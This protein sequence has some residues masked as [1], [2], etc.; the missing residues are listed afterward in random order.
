MDEYPDSALLLLQDIA[1]PQILRGKER[2]DYALLY[3]QACDKNYISKS[4][5]SSNHTKTLGSTGESWCIEKY[6]CFFEL[7]LFRMCELEQRK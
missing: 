2:A 4:T 6:G 1:F 5:I 3:T 7:F